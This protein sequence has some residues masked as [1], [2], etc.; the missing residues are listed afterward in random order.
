M[1]SMYGKGNKSIPYLGY[2]VPTIAWM[3]RMNNGDDL[4]H[5]V[6]KEDRMTGYF[7]T[8]DQMEP[9]G[10]EHWWRQNGLHLKSRRA[11]VYSECCRLW[12]NDPLDDLSKVMENR[13]FLLL[14]KSLFSNIADIRYAVMMIYMYM[15]GTCEPYVVGE[16]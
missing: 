2:T 11:Q 14:E 7:K 9:S 13:G 16:K 15:A 4:G 6:T 8:I 5:T 10:I 1:I 12:L 3:C